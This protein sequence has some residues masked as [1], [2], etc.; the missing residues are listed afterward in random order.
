MDGIIDPRADFNTQKQQFINCIKN[1]LQ[2]RLAKNDINTN[3]YDRYMSLAYTVLDHMVDSWI[4]TDRA[5]SEAKPKRIHYI[6]M[7]FLMGRALS[8]NLISLGL[9]DV[10]RDA[11][12]ELGYDLE[13]TADFEKDAALGNGGLGRLAACFLDSMTNLGIP[14]HG[15]GILYDY[16]MMKQ[17]IQRDR[18]V[19]KPDVWLNIPYPWSISRVTETTEV[20][21]GGHVV[22][23]DDRDTTKACRWDPLQKLLAEA[24]DIP[25]YGYNNSNVNV[26]RLWSARSAGEFDLDSFSEGKYMDAC[27]A[28]VFSESITKVLYPN[29]KDMSGKR[30]RFRQEYFLAAASLR[31]IINRFRREH[32]GDFGIFADKVGIQLND[33]HPGL[34]IAELMRI[35]VDEENIGWDK[36]WEITGK[37]FAYTNH[38]VLPEALEEWPVSLVEELLP[39][40]MEI[41]YNINH[42]FMEQVGIRYPGDFGKMQRMSVINDKSRSVRIA[43]LSIVGSHKVNGVAALH[44]ELLKKDLFRDFAQMYPERFVSVTNGVTP[45]RWMFSANPALTALI[46]E[47]IG[48]GWMQDLEKLIELEPF[49]EDSGFR[50][51]WAKVKAGNKKRFS[52]F[53]KKDA[54]LSVDPSFMLDV[55]V[56]RIH[57]YKRQLLFLLY[58]LYRYYDI[59]KNPGKYKVPRAFVMGGKASPSYWA[60]KELIYF[61]NRVSHII[62]SDPEV[63]GQIEFVFM[64]DYR[65]SSAE[66]IMPAADLSEQISTAGYEASG[67]GNMKFALNGA[68]TI[69]TLDGANVEIK[70][71][72]GEDNIFIFGMNEKEA[73]ELKERYDPREYVEKYPEIKTI[74]ELVKGD[75]FCADNPGGLRFFADYLTGG[76]EYLVMADFDSYRKMQEQVD[77]LYENTDEWVR[78]SVLNVARCGYF[79]S[80]RSI[81]EY[82]EKIWKAEPVVLPR[83]D[84]GR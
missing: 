65:V 82:N 54:G 61:A 49:S 3:D 34:C 53:L 83:I 25:V 29:D 56:K 48:D 51:E 84:Y 70:D 63:K 62:S 9:Y 67:T 74:L 68:L 43:N 73:R 23:S 21:F 52:A 50:S 66:I 17:T 46:K 7:E 77:A 71:C 41:I 10:A 76:D 16:G 28:Q 1:N 47:A 8:N 15:Y 5:Y 44:S 72:V 40:H 27:Q 80:D 39:R 36:A 69:G 79:S 31:D 20:H 4:K 6:S 19:E 64:P 35:L 12:C 32:N 18:Q 37:V 59:R 60:A 13:E 75:F 33:T 26:L 58:I 78:R 45:R 81:K 11:F 22:H 14:T 30:L 24:H 57:F 38:T 42:F 55:Q 2:R